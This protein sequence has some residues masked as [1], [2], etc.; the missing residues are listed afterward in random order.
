MGTVSNMRIEPMGVTFGEDVMQKEKITCIAD[1]SSSLNSQFFVF[2]EPAG[3]KRYCWFNV[4]GSGVDPAVSGATGHVVAISANASA[5]TVA[6]AVQAVLDIVAGFDCSVDGA[7]LTLTRTAAGSCKPIHDGAADTGFA[8]EVLVYGDTAV[9]LGFSDGDI[10]V[11]KEENYVALTSHQTG[12]VELSHISTGAIV[13][14]TVN[15]KETAFSQLRKLIG[16][17]EGDVML[18]KGTGAGATEVIGWGTNRQ[19]KQTLERARKLVLHPEA[20][21]SSD[22][23]RDITSHKAFAKVGSLTYSGEN[24][25]VC[26]V[27][28]TIYP[29][30]TKASQVRMAAIGDGS[31]TLT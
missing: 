5:A 14:I 19:F 13:T 2:Y 16:T 24:V 10:E 17:G 21:A 22:K 20:L 1:V 31:Q 23:S 12:T 26:P 8:F 15:V 25:L 28:F 27:E 6:S 3:T 30:Y 7:V 29:D 18:P 11:T 4:G 9:D